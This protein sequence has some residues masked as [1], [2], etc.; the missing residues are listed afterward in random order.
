MAS[1]GQCSSRLPSEME[2]KDVLEEI[3][4]APGAMGRGRVPCPDRPPK[5]AY[6]VYRWFS[7]S[8]AHAYRRAPD[9]AQIPFPGLFPVF[10]AK[11]RDCALRSA[12]PCEFGQ[13][14]IGNRICF[15]CFLRKDLR[16]HSRFWD[17]ADL[18][19]EVVSED[20]PERDLVEKR[21]DYAEAR[22]SEYWIVNPQSAS[23]TVL[24]LKDSG[25]EEAG[26]YRRGES[27]TSLLVPNFSLDV[28]AVFDSIRA[29][30]TGTTLLL[31]IIVVPL[32]A[33]ANLLFQ[34]R[35]HAFVFAGNRAVKLLPLE[36]VQNFPELG[37]TLAER[38]DLAPGPILL[39]STMCIVK[40][41]PSSFFTPSSGTIPAAAQWPR[42]APEPMNGRSFRSFATLIRETSRL[43]V[44]VQP[45]FYL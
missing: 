44:V 36:F 22:V 43:R 33:L 29:K 7:G 5:S 41:R 45:N 19:L 9:A 37:C 38:N 30:S 24:R 39:I 2:W 6:R 25:Y 18:A 15:C 34:R 31:E 8:A 4:P 13:A 20:K 35:R 23:I 10:R 32:D 1:A 12:A 40:K 11:S 26:T 42:S 3:L 27:A 17:G 14:S 21:G 16:R 28:G